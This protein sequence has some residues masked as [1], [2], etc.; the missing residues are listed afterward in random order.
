MVNQLKGYEM[1]NENRGQMT[2]T[3]PASRGRVACIWAISLA[4]LLASTM[5]LSAAEP[6]FQ[7]VDLSP[8]FHLPWS[9]YRP[10]HEWTPPSA[11]R[12]LLN[13]VPFELAGVV[14][15]TGMNQVNTDFR[16][17]SAAFPVGRKFTRVHLLHHS[18][19]SSGTGSPV[20]QMVLHYADESE[21]RFTVRFRVHLMDWYHGSRAR[22]AMGSTTTYAW[23]VPQVSQ[24]EAVP[25][26]ALWHTWVPNPH[27]ERVVDRIEFVSAF[28]NSSYTLDALTLEQGEPLPELV[29]SGPNGSW[30]VV[31][32]AI[33][34]EF[35]V[36]DDAEGGPIAGA[37][38]NVWLKEGEKQLVWGTYESDADGRLQVRVPGARNLPLRLIAI[39]RE[40]MPAAFE[41][42]PHSSDGVDQSAPLKLRRGKVIGGRVVN[43]AGTGIADVSVTINSILPVPGGGFALCRWPTVRSDAS[44]AWTIGAAPDDFQ[45]LTLQLSHPNHLPASYEQG[46]EGDAFTISAVEL[47]KREAKTELTAG[48]PLTGSV[49]GTDGRPLAGAAITLFSGYDPR[50]NRRLA[51]TGSD[52]AFSLAN[53]LPGEAVLVATAPGHGPVLQRMTLGP[54]GGTARI[55]LPAAQRLRVRVRDTLGRPVPGAFVMPVE[56]QNDAWLSWLGRTDAAGQVEW[57]AAPAEPVAYFVTS[58]LMST[59]KVT[60]PADGAEHEVQ[61]ESAPTVKLTVVDAETGEP[62]PVFT[63]IRGQ[64]YGGGQ[65]SWETYTPLA[66]SNG[67]FLLELDDARGAPQGWMLQVKSPGYY[68][69]ATAAFQTSTNFVLKL[70]RGEPPRGVVVDA[71]GR[72]VAGAQVVIAGENTH[73]Y[74]DEPPLFRAMGREPVLLS[75]ADGAFELPIE[76]DTLGVFVA[77]PEAGFGR[78]SLAELKENGKVV[79]HAWARVEGVLKVG[80]SIEAGQILSIHRNQRGEL[81]DPRDFRQRLGLYAKAT[82][83]P[84]GRFVFE[85]IPP[86]ELELA[87]QY[88]TRSG[89]SIVWSHSVPLDLAP[90]GMTNVVVGGTGRSIIGRVKPDETLAAQIDYARDSHQL[91]AVSSIQ[92]PQF[93]QP[94]GARDQESIRAAIDAYQAKMREFNQSEAGRQYRRDQR[95]YAVRFDAT[96]GFRADNI[97]P[98]NYALQLNFT[99]PGAQ[100]YQNEPLANHY[101]PLTVEEGTT[102]VDLGEIALRGRSN[103]RPGQ[104]APEIAMTDLEGRPVKL[105]D[106][107]GRTVLLMIWGTA[108]PEYEQR[109]A[110]LKKFHDKHRGSDKLVVLALAVEMS[111]GQVKEAMA[112][113]G[114]DWTHAI[115]QQPAGS[116]M[117]QAYAMAAGQPR[118]AEFKPALVHLI[119]KNGRLMGSTHELDLFLPA[120]EQIAGLAAP[121]AAAE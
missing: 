20:A 42:P 13:G 86:M 116:E 47:L 71:A 91:T 102:P 103:V 27:P 96:G 58:P 104:P 79:V 21:Y 120:V 106:F 38:I 83:A 93:K 67:S 10:S 39:G 5:A 22:A 109:L 7:P 37:R 97:P 82:P 85:K 95:A 110:S 30:P 9:A 70:Q 12:Q 34:R 118:G 119:D 69:G 33:V 72:P 87:L 76:L 84:D 77:H 40:H 62:L 48:V 66:G 41:L 46:D 64:S 1:T 89:Q 23:Y 19:F 32:P 51:E 14:Q 4:G 105:A 45:N 54:E 114:Y 17:T 121:P 6:Q 50:S 75:R 28:G 111:A 101:Q 99:M 16:P 26:T 113:K 18:E 100:E 25:F 59:V 63:V 43:P 11:G 3:N 92:P 73:P 107:R 78:A 57:D 35:R 29:E 52:G 117:V 56:W 60:L 94:E 108:L 88:P 2:R 36:V 24:P 15:L 112:G 98:G 8:H 80:E 44:G 53:L 68:P 61:L 55:Q 90:G 74:M 31:A 49:A 65:A 81:Y 115:P